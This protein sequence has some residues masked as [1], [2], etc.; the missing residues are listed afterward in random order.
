MNKQE[1][2]D[3]VAKKA[4]ITKK[5]AQA[6]IDAAIEAIIDAVKKG[7]KVTLVGFGTFSSVKRAA[8]NGRNPA[9]GITMKIAARKSPKFSAG[10]NFKEKVK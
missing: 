9:T 2:V 1:L 4:K 10:K 5:D 3:S 8:R 7:D 6:T